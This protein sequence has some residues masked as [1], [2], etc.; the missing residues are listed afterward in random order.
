MVSSGKTL[1]FGIPA[2]RHVLNKRNS[3]TNKKVNP[4]CLVLSPTRELAQQVC[5]SICFYLQELTSYEL[6]IFHFMFHDMQ[7]PLFLN[8]ASKC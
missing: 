2:I 8:K 6:N 5:P 4:R 7:E 1:A 3:S